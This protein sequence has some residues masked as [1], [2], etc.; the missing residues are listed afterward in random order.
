MQE[1]EHGA[2]AKI[3]RALAKLGLTGPVASKAD[4]LGLGIPCS[5]DPRTATQDM[6]IGSAN[7]GFFY[8]VQGGGTI[9]K[10][11]LQVQASSGNICVGVYANT[12]AGRAAAP[13]AR[14]ASSGIVACPATG[15][16]EVALGASVDVKHGEHWLYFWLDN[17]TATVKA[18]QTLGTDITKGLSGY[19]DNATPAPVS[20]PGLLNGNRHYVLVGVA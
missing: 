15:Y 3:D 9:S 19:H 18:V 16:A 6:T 4:P 8:R 2:Q 17:L 7:R 12:G 11:A 1:T 14:L 20:A 13:G 5:T 10:I